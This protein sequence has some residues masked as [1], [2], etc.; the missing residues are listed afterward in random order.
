MRELIVNTGDFLMGLQS[1]AD[2]LDEG[3]ELPRPQE[4][5]WTKKNP[6]FIF[7]FLTKAQNK[8]YLLHAN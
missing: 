4:V 6:L 5:A 2:G 3:L 8:I 7:P 1:T